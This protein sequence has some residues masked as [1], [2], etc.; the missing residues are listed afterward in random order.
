MQM[1]H[2]GLHIHLDLCMPISMEEDTRKI[3]G[4]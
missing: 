3:S 4:W 2:S 1:L